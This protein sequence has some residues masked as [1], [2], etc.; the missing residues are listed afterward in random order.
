MRNELLT[1]IG[2]ESLRIRS[3]IVEDVTIDQHKLTVVRSKSFP[4]VDHFEWSENS[5][6][7]SPIGIDERPE[8]APDLVA[9]FIISA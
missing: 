7:Q 4:A 6:E 9:V 8:R 5:K 2:Y 1:S 3:K